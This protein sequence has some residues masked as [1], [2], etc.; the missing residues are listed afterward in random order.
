MK[1]NKIET[2]SLFSFEIEK[3]KY[4]F[5]QVIHKEGRAITV[6]VFNLLS[7]E[8][9]KFNLDE[10]SADKI[11]L[12]LTTMQNFFKLG[13]WFL[14]EKLSVIYK[15]FLKTKFKV[16]TPEGL[17]SINHKGEI[18]HKISESEAKN[19]PYMKNVSPSVVVNTSKAFFG[20]IP[21]E[22]YYENFLI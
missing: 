2:G 4:A 5:G 8:K 6:V 1:R 18:L 12:T 22:E 15:D 11:I 14:L 16:M 19:L 21:K 9:D 7:D 10:F 3:N 20:V 17:F 13:R